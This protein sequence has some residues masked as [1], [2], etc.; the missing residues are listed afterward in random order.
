VGRNIKILLFIEL[1]IIGIYFFDKIIFFN[2]QI[3]ALSA[4]LV[5]VATNYTHKRIVRSRVESGMYQD[6]DPLDKID[7]PY[8]LYEKD[9]E[10]IQEDVS[11]IDLKAVL[12]EEKRRMK[13]M[14]AKGF[15]EGIRGSFS[16]WRLGAYCFL[17]FGFIALKNNGI[18]HIGAYLPALLIGIIAGYFAS[19]G[20]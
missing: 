20:E 2:I 18:L 13:M 10:E 19:K 8:E 7:D 12:Q 16:L 9:E 14:R 11:Q 1:S 4:F 6:N 17:I 5:I 3:A 15:K